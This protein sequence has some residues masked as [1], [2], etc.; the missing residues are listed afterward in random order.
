MIK[1]AAFVLVFAILLIL[2]FSLRAERNK[3]MFENLVFVTYDHQGDNM[4]IGSYSTL[5]KKG[6]LSVFLNREKDS[7]YY[8]YQ[9]TDDELAKVKFLS[10]KKLKNFVI[11]REL[12]VGMG[13]A[14]SCNYL[15]YKIG[16]DE[17]KI[18]F[19]QPF[20]DKDFNEA[21]MVIDSK[22]FI[23]RDSFKVAR[24]NIDFENIKKEI[25]RQETFDS[26]LPKKQL[27]Y[28]PRSF[29]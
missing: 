24:F 21:V 13:Y 8:K 20:M 25:L 7:V 28:P 16:N 15:S 26:Y 14:G 10:S 5:D 17:D 18:C 23:Q 11:K 2:L 29:R 6:L 3:V 19:I 4:K 22:V 1:K 27:P 12:D 9:L